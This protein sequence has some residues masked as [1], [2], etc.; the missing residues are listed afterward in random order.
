[1]GPHVCV[2]V[3]MHRSFKGFMAGAGDAG[4]VQEQFLPR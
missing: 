4:T 1:M 2:N 3:N